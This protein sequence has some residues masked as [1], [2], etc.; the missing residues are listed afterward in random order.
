M[1]DPETLNLYRNALLDKWHRLEHRERM[2]K[3]ELFEPSQADQP[4]DHFPGSREKLRIMQLRFASGQ[5]LF[6]PEDAER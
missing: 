5:E 1:V 3:S 4:T 6:H 2:L